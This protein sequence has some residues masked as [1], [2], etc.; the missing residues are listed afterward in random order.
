MKTL[1]LHIGLGKTG[2]TSIQLA[3]ENIPGS[4]KDGTSYPRAPLETQLLGDYLVQALKEPALPP[5]MN[6]G[7]LLNKLFQGSGLYI[8]SSESIGH[9]LDC[10]KTALLNA[11]IAFFDRIEIIAYVRDPMLWNCKVYAQMHLD[12]PLFDLLD[13]PYLVTQSALL[14]TFNDYAENFPAVNLNVFAYEAACSHAKG[15][16][17]HFISEVAR[18]FPSSDLSPQLNL[19]TRSDSFANQKLTVGQYVCAARMR[20]IANISG[21]DI[22]YVPPDWSSLVIGEGCGSDLLFPFSH[23]ESIAVV[24]KYDSICLKNDFGIDSS[25]SGASI[26]LLSKAQPAIKQLYDEY[27]ECST[28]E[29]CIRL[30][31]S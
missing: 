4:M 24:S 6:I 5:E 31:A 22:S 15:L 27:L 26:D 20:D 19:P 8:M 1:L 16:L 3:L 12:F 25:D 21:A 14:R 30:L 7:N 13:C 23:I 17:G 9:S 11:F 29:S 2:S 10:H 28:Y 18:I